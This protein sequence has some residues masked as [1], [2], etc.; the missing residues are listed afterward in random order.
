VAVGWWNLWR[1]VKVTW[2]QR[3][4]RGRVTVR[5]GVKYDGRAAVGLVLLPNGDSISG[6][7]GSVPLWTLLAHVQTNDLSIRVPVYLTPTS[8]AVPAAAAWMITLLV[9]QFL[10]PLL[11]DFA[12][13]QLYQSHEESSGRAH[14]A[15]SAENPITAVLATSVPVTLREVA[16]K[17][18]ELERKTAGLVVLSVTVDGIQDELLVDLLQFWTVGS[19]VSLPISEIRDRF[20][21]D[22]EEVNDEALMKEWSWYSLFSSLKKS[23]RIAPDTE[24]TRTDANRVSVRYQ[25]RGWSYESVFRE[26]DGWIRIPDKTVARTTRLGR[27]NVVY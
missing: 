17:K 6:G 18:R 4:G 27:S 7:S 10:E 11:E 5:Y 14:L 15:A 2:C 3:L 19:S 1:K 24:S 8:A 13:T 23:T 22:R 16:E 26:D 12:S 20:N 21:K 9:S 25:Y